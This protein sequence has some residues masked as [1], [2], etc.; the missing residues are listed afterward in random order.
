M[1]VV[2]NALK[3]AMKMMD[4]KK[5]KGMVDDMPHVILGSGPNK[6]V[7]PVR[8]MDSPFLVHGGGDDGGDHQVDMAAEEFIERMFKELRTQ[9]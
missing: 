1:A 3:V 5:C 6:T 9:G 7:R 4:D 2:N 8:V